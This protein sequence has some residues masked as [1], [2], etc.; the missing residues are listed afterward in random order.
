VTPVANGRAGPLF[1]GGK[2]KFFNLP[3]LAKN[4]KRAHRA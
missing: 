4:K 1:A 3:S 2:S